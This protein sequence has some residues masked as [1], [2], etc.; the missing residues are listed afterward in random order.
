MAV[1]AKWYGPAATS[2]FTKKVNITSDTLK[3][4]LCTSSYVPDQDNHQFQSSITNEVVGTGYTAGGATLGSVTLSY[5]AGTNILTFDAADT[6]WGPGATFTA[7]YAIVVDT[8]P[9]TAA[10]NPLLLYVDFGADV[11]VS[12]G[13][14]TITWDA[15]GLGTVT[16]S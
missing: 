8:T 10:T 5:N 3:V 1:S 11:P 16:V 6:S 14:F 12:N 4:M 15:N 7:R 13:T 2:F 9:G